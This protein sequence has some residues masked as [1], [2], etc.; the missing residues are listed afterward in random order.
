[1]DV[2]SEIAVFCPYVTEGNYKLVMISYMLPSEPKAPYTKKNRF[3]WKC[4]GQV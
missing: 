2:I 1:M 3:Q 4:K